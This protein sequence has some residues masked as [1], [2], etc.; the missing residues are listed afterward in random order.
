ARGSGGADGADR[1]RRSRKN[2]L[3]V[4][5]R[6]EVGRE[7]AAY[8]QRMLPRAAM[9]ARSRLRELSVALVGER[10]MVRLHRKFMGIA[11][12]TDVLSF[13][14]DGDG[15]EGELIICV[16]VA[17]RQ[18]RVHGTKAAHEALLYALHGMLHLSGMDD[19]TARE[20]KAMHRVEDAILRRL[21]V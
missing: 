10:E 1:V 9:A 17:R 13:D 21:G 7:Y 12:P 4:N 20:S 5:I 11:G 16:P 19:R 14:L 8:L 6:A 18:A 3:R 2:R 15:R